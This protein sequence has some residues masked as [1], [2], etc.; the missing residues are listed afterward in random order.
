MKTTGYVSPNLNLLPDI[1]RAVKEAL[2]WEV[3]ELPSRTR[4]LR[5]EVEIT[6]KV[7]GEES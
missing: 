6:V 2:K 4:N 7:E 5:I 1:E 3:S